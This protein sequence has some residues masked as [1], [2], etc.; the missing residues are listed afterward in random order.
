MAASSSEGGPLAEETAPSNTTDNDPQF[1]HT[2]SHMQKHTAL[3]TVH[4]GT[5]WESLAA[6]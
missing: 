1:T 6:G 4:K 3:S 5:Y 2:P